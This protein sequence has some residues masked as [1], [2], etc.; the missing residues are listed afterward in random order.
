MIKQNNKLNITVFVGRSEQSDL[1]HLIL[2]S[3]EKRPPISHLTFCRSDPT[4]ATRAFGVDL[5]EC[6]NGIHTVDFL[7]A[8]IRVGRSEQ[9]DF[10]QIAKK[11][12]KIIFFQPQKTDKNNLQTQTETNIRPILPKVTV[13]SK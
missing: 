5:G 11:V 2:H 7:V 6:L 13:M 10:R 9:N 8:I 4:N 12:T 1:R 3:V